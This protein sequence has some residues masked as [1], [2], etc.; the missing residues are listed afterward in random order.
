VDLLSVVE[1]LLVAIGYAAAPV[2]ANT[3]LADVPSI[4]VIAV[5]VAVVA[6]FA[7]R[8]GEGVPGEELAKQAQVALSVCW[9]A[10]GVSLLAIGLARRRAVLRHAGLA[11]LA[12]AIAK[13]VLIDMASMDVAYR[14]LVLFGLGLLLLAGAWLLTRFRGPRAGSS[15]STA[16]VRPA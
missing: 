13:V 6:V 16:S 1:L 10:I 3:V 2:I 12:V 9:T 8:A 4:G 15:S 11:L 7:R 14:A 5:S